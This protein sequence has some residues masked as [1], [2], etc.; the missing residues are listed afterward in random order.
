MNSYTVYFYNCLSNHTCIYLLDMKHV[1]VPQVEIKLIILV[2]DSCLTPQF[3]V[4]I[5]TKTSYILMR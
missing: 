5:M 1:N 4:V 3:S 2:S